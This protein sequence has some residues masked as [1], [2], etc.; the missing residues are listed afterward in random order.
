M[1]AKELRG[2]DAAALEKEVQD[3]L[4]A[5]FSLRMQRATQQLQDTSQL[6]KVR[7]DIARTR[8]ILAEKANAK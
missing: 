3:L 6:R 1:D 7:R 2:K 5:H 4:K 8:T